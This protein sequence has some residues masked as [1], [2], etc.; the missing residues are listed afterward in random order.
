M[1]LERA[2]GKTEAGIHFRLKIYID[3]FSFKIRVLLLLSVQVKAS[4]E[5]Q[6]IVFRSR[7]IYNQNK[8]PQKPYK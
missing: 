4:D 8:G 3:S 1:I 2:S 5:I 6:F 7:A